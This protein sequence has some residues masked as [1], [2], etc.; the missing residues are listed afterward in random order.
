MKSQRSNRIFSGVVENDGLMNVR[1]YMNNI[2][3]QFW[4]SLKRRKVYKITP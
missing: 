2:G 4:S 1:R 3:G